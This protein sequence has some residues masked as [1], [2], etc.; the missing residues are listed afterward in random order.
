RCPRLAPPAAQAHPDG[1]R[2][3]SGTRPTWRTARAYGPLLAAA[4]AFTVM[5]VTVPVASR[6]RQEFAGDVA[7]PDIVNP[8]GSVVEGPGG[9]GGTGGGSATGGRSGGST[10]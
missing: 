7:I 4:V 6:E 9:T 8:D 10:G 5:A 2:G 3:M 1:G